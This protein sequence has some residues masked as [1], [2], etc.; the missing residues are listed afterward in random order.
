M[1]RETRHLWVGNL[2][3]NVREE[4]IIEH[5]KRYGRVESV[6][7]L[8][9]RGSEGGVAA[10]VDFVDIKSAQKAHNTI[11]KMGDRDLRTD[12]NEPGTIPS[13][14]RGLE[15]SLSIAT[16]GRD[17]SGFTRGAGATVYGPPAS[18][19]SREGRYERRLDGASESRERTYDHSAYGHHERGCGSSFDR[20]RHYDTEYYR[21]PRDRTLSGGGI[22]S[23][24]SSSASTG[25]ASSVVTGGSVGTG[26]SS[27]AVGG[28]GGNATGTGSGGSTSGG[29]SFYGSRCRSPGRFETTETRYEARARESYTLASV[30][31]RDL[32]RDERGRRGDRTYPH[33]R[34]RSPHTSQSHNVSPQRFSSPAAR[35]PPSPSGSGS[36]SRSSSSDSE[37]STSSSG[38]GSESSSSSSDESPA[39]SVQSAAVPAPSSQPLPP[40]DKDEPRKSFGIKVQNLPVRSTDTS[41]KDGLFHE[42]KKHGKV[43]SVQIHGASEER[44]G[45]VF[46]RQQED[47]EKA[48]SASKGKLFFGMQIDVTAWTG[49]ETESE[50]EFRPLDERIDEFHP[51]AT[52]TLFIGNLEKTTSYHDLLNIFQRFGDIV[53]IDIKKVNGAPQYAFLQ[54]CDIASVCKAIKKMDGEYLGSNRLKLGFGKSMPTTCVWLDG[55]AS[56]ITEQYLTRHFCRYGHVVKVVFDRLKG[57]A[58]VLYNNI[59]CAQAAVK[60]TKGWKIGGN[61]IKVDFANHES[62]MAFYRS[63]QASGQDIRDFYDILSDRRDERRPLYH[64]FSTERACYENVRTPPAYTEEL[65]RKYSARSREFYSEWDPYTTD[66]YDPRYY[67]EPCEFR[68]Y[69]DPYEQDIRK[70]S[71]MQR[72]RNRDRERFETDRERDHSRR[73][74]EHNQSPT[75]PRRPSSPTASPVLTE[76]LVND[77]EHHIYSRS[78]ERSGS[79]SSI[80]PPRFEKPDRIRLERYSKSDKLE[81]ERPLF[82]ADRGSGGEKERRAGRKEKVEKDRTEKHRLR[83]LKLSSPSIPSSETDLE[84]DREISPDTAQS[85]S[86]K[87]QAKEK[88]SGKGRLDLPPCVVHLTRVKEKEGKFIDHAIVEKQRVKDASDHVGSPNAPLLADHKTMLHRIEIQSREVFK[89]GKIPK[90]KCLS[91]QVETLDKEAKNK[92]RKYLKAESVF[93][94]SNSDADRL[95]ARKRRFEEEI[96]RSNHLRRITHDEDE[97]RFGVKWLGSIRFSKGLDEDKKFAQLE[98]PKQESRIDKK[99][100][101]VY[102]SSTSEEPD[103]EMSRHLGNNLD[104]Q[105]KELVEEETESMNHLDQRMLG[106]GAKDQQCPSLKVND[107][108]NLKTEQHLIDLKKHSALQQIDA[109]N[110][111]ERL[112]FDLDHSKSCRKQ[113][114]Q[115]RR[116]YQQLQDCDNTSKTESTQS[117]DVQDFNHQV[118]R[119]LPLDLSDVSPPLKRKRSEAFDYHF[120]T[121]KECNNQGSWQLK[122]DSERN[123]TSALMGEDLPADLLHG[124]ADK[125]K[126]IPK[127]ENNSHWDGFKCNNHN[128]VTDIEIFKAKKSLVGKEGLC[129]ESKTKQDTLKEMSFPSTIVK[130]DSI[131]KRPVHELEPGE[132]RSDTDGDDDCDDDDD[133]DD[134]DDYTHLSPKMDSFIK[135]ECEENIL[136]LKLSG[137]L[138]KKRFYEFAL[139]KTITPDTKALLERAKSLS[140][141]REDNWSF[142]GYDSQFTNFRNCTNKEKVEPT[143]RPIPSWYMKKKKIRSDSEGK[144]F[145][146]KEDPKREEQE[147]GKLFASRFMHSSIFEQDS[148][149]LRRLECKDSYPEIGISREK[150]TITVEKAETVKSDFVQEPIV[151]FHNRFL[152]LQQ[153]KDQESSEHSSET[154]T[155]AESVEK[156]TVPDQEQV[157]S[158]KKLDVV[159]GSKSVSPSLS[160]SLLSPTETLLHQNKPTCPGSESALLPIKDETF[161]ETQIVSDQLTSTMNDIKATLAV[162]TPPLINMDAKMEPK[163]EKYEN[164][165]I[166]VSTFAKEQNA[167][168]KLPTPGEG[169]SN[170]EAESDP[171]E[172]LS[173]VPAKGTEVQLPFKVEQAEEKTEYIDCNSQ[174]NVESS[175]EMQLVV[176][177]PE[178]ELTQPARKQTKN[179]KTKA[180]P[181]ALLPMLPT[182]PTSIEK[183][184]I[185]KSERI[186][187]EKLKRTSSPKI[188]SDSKNSSKSPVYTTDLEQ[189]IDPSMPNGRTRQRRNVR[190]VYAT[191]IEDE[192]Q[193]QQGKDCAEPSR[194]MRKRADKESVQQDVCTP[195]A[196]TRRGRPPKTR[197][198]MDGVT[199]SKG[200]QTNTSEVDDTNIKESG[201]SDEITKV[202]EGWRSPRSQKVQAI[203]RVGQSRKPAKTDKPSEVDTSE[204]LKSQV[205]AKSETT[206]LEKMVKKTEPDPMDK[207]QIS[208]KSVKVKLPRETR[209][210]KTVPIDNSVNLKNLVIDLSEDAVKDALYSGDESSQ[211]SQDPSKKTESDLSIKEDSRTVKDLKDVDDLSSDEREDAVSDVETPA[212]PEAVF[213]ARQ[214]ELERA[215]ENISN[216]AVEQPPSYKEPSCQ[217]PVVSTP[218]AAEPEQPEVEKPANPAS[219]TELAAAIDS[220]TTENISADADG[221]HTPPT[222]TSLLPPSET[223]VL[224]TSNE[225]VEPETDLVIK[226]VKD[227][228]SSST[229]YTKLSP[230]TV[231]TKLPSSEVPKKG[232]RPRLKTTKKY[233]GRKISANKKS[234]SISHVV[235]EAELTAVKLPE[236]I[237]EDMQS[238]NPKTATSAAAATVVTVAAACKHDVASVVTLNTPKEAEQPAIDQPEPQESAFHSGTKSPSYLRSPNTLSETVAL[239]L[240]PPSTC[241]NVTP[242]HSAKVPH[243]IPDWVNRTEENVKPPIHKVAVVAS[244]STVVL[245]GHSANTANP[246]DTKASDIDPS[247]STL[248]KILMEPKYVSALNSSSVPS[249]LLT[250]SIND[251]RVS[252]NESSPFIKPTVLEDRPNPVTPVT[253][254]MVFPQQPP[255]Q[256]HE[257]LNI[258]KE[259]MGNTVISSTATSVISRIPMPFDFDNT[260]HISLSNRS[261]GPSQPKHKYRFGMND[262]NRYHGLSNLD[263]GRSSDNTPSNTG[264]GPG[265]RVN[266]SEGVMVLSYSGQ[267]TE[268]PQRIVAKISQIPPASAVDIE[269]QQ[270]VSKSHIKQ[271][272]LQPPTPKT[273]QTSTAQGHT[274]TILSNQGFSTQHVISSIK[275]E[276]P[277]SDKPESSPNIASQGAPLKTF[278]HL[279]P[280][281][282]VLRYNQPM[283]Q[284]H[285]IKKAS[286][287]SVSV[288]ADVKQ[289]QSFNH[290]PVLSPHPS[291]LPGNHISSPNTPNDRLVCHPKHDL[292]CPR[293][294]ASP[295]SKVCPPSA[296]V[297]LGASGPNYGTNVHHSE[298]SVIMHNHNATQSVTIGQ[299]S[300][301]NVRMNTPPLAGINYG[302]RSDSLS[303]S[304]SGPPQRSTTPQPAIMRERLLKQHASAGDLGGAH[305]NDARLFHHGTRRTSLAQLHSDVV[306]MQ[307]EYKAIHHTGLHLDHYNRDL[308][309]LMPKQLTEHQGVLEAH[310]AQ[311]PEPPSLSSPPHLSSASSKSPSVKNPPLTLRDSPNAMEVKMPQSTHSPH[312]ECRVIGHTPGSVISAQGVQR[313]HPGSPGSMPEFYRE[314][315]GF[316]SQL[317]GSSVIGINIANYGIAPSQSSLEGEHRSKAAHIAS[318]GPLRETTLSMPHVRLPGS[319]DMSR[320]HRIQGENT[321]PSYTSPNSIT[322]KSEL[323]RSL[324][325]GPQ[326]LSSVLVSLLPSAPPNIRPDIKP[327]NA[328][329]SVVDMVQLLTKYPIVWQGHLALKNDSAAVQL[330]FVSGNNVLAHRSLPPSEGGP[331]LRIAQRMRL[332]ASQLEGVAR[333][334]T[335]EDDYCLLLALPCGLDQDDVL[336]QTHALKTC[337]ITYLQAKQ[338]AGIINVPNPGSNQPAYVVQI[339]PPCEFSESHLSHLAPDLLKSISSISPHLM[340]VIASV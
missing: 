107:D 263:D 325:K 227:F 215:V 20:Q 261:T 163:E 150:A 134:Y 166:V 326:G 336:I 31:H 338:A 17:V 333:R 153:K 32:Y 42:F 121:N 302:I 245:G 159:I 49:P 27:S 226:N 26:S 220:I 123:V 112:P 53:D 222:Y 171:A 81:K 291:P 244:A 45:L 319:L 36:R 322:S 184:T 3:E 217:P 105:L 197:K 340:I 299:L 137:S 268:G 168:G 113:M 180:N 160:E 51:K 22:G 167:D 183:P 218:V 146:Q 246:P 103:S 181:S 11:N 154:N 56:N 118:S 304:T 216:L 66:Y 288:K 120:A 139:D 190:S 40:V 235:L 315:H 212:G 58:L 335:L 185:R 129:W 277:V 78:S 65:R 44:Y 131:R 173:P 151:L 287:E 200:E 14:A 109:L 242:S 170:L 117:T 332:E 275:K 162:I 115:S 267:K 207:P 110:S 251:P 96:T 297:G 37:S 327:D 47:Q 187:R 318:G 136:D 310:K 9:K 252:E 250:T 156:M 202:A 52:R 55:L 269:F 195:P 290:S 289:S 255:P 6:K 142:L 243:T 285:H 54:Y 272:Q 29:G 253:P 188:M 198:R 2:P 191:P 63:M 307:P 135:R 234:D 97:G 16:R 282:H 61:K 265:L 328:G 100:S 18:L 83:K 316:H 141:S 330:H 7:V 108:R 93:E 176:S 157:Q 90:D 239:A 71:Y 59:E 260:P 306:V 68:D 119:K 155:E 13:A 174:Q 331:P 25:V 92:C 30:V 128:T 295:F 98:T 179:K 233:K 219:E 279:S 164:K 126:N 210:T 60:E 33:S 221:F 334:M 116:L 75:H 241:L 193:Q 161:D 258:F 35:P 266:T 236:S 320:V 62:Q 79:C 101:L 145:D 41:L 73:T 19:H 178:V 102:I 38:S 248:R 70:Y 149:R 214:M 114:E 211:H 122:D 43:T 256:H 259:K 237:P 89:P 152:E 274:G 80:S 201:K 249:T 204:S 321:S 186:D 143:P 203:V 39:R 224:P 91:S 317:P 292:H 303:S 206:S 88:E 247:S 257:S 281:H 169:S 262:S 278:Q 229:P 84:P 273:P 148:R 280:R 69:R 199:L 15:D 172:C 133:D 10:F 240:T 189:I 74:A 64:E 106:L 86:G 296:S 323:S 286:A 238:T 230:P 264:S 329:Q 85:N 82:D 298:Q 177:E 284:Q 76:R 1:V 67:D 140:S 209:N 313:I 276:G 132:V 125:A 12:Y 194:S 228:E 324:Q 8:P 305:E 231:V 314:M 158:P 48:L 254:Q 57:M 87:T 50:N 104:L 46:F 99:E 182:Q 196:N 23:A 300:Q 77:S 4:K 225:V 308:R 312:S 130:R 232:G 270:S 144:L 127:Q 147:S 24:S 21:D 205:K 309:V 124:N 165:G 301:G 34:S 72:E 311:T 337:F 138:E 283:L 208:E 271:E 213:L 294:L 94:K 111:E 192:V 293:T 223:L 175:L 95:A 339:F 28:S 5:F